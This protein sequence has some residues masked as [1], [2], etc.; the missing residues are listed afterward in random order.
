LGH[1][2]SHYMSSAPMGTISTIMTGPIVRLYPM[3]HVSVCILFRISGEYSYHV[4]NLHIEPWTH[5]S[6]M[7]AVSVSL[8]C[9]K[10]GKGLAGRAASH[11]A[12]YWSA[13]LRYP[14]H[15]IEYVL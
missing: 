3:A 1:C 4:S 6:S 11:I 12:L 5:G 8:A 2:L 10:G 14:R 13:L 7:G 15:V 9:Q